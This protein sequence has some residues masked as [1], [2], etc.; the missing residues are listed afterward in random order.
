M[1]YALTTIWHERSR[2]LP[3]ILAVSFSATLITVQGGL[4]I[5]LLSM[6][7]V[8]I[9]Q[10]AA[11]V[12]VG[13]P[14]VRSVD[15]GR[16]IPERWV[17]RVAADPAVERVETC[18]IGFSL[19][20]RLSSDRTPATPEIITIV[21]TRLHPDALGAMDAIRHDPDL[22]AKLA[23]PST[24]AVDES[25]LGRLGDLQLGG[26]AEIF[27]RRVRLVGLVHGYKSLGGPYV[28]CNVDT[29]RQ[30]LKQTSG[31][32]TYLQAK[33][34]KGA[35][36]AATAARLNRAYPTLSAFT[37]DEFSLR[38]RMHWLTTTKAGIA[39]GF[40][41]LLALLV[42]AVV[43]SQTLYGATIAFQREFATMRAMGI[44]RWRLQLTVLTQSLWVGALG[45]LLSVPVVAVLSE[46]AS[47]LGT[48]VRLHPVVLAVAGGVTL[49]MSFVSGLAAMRSFQGVDPAHNIR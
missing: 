6:I 28:F 25:E 36:A 42:G 11:N 2:F 8:P 5:G 14:G 48:Q 33:L 44:P 37:S 35:D 19:W 26:H 15:L 10:S 3:A 23:E 20:S 18:V 7:S 49:G 27:G 45:I 39:V 31:G 29:A 30:L 22:M 43:T 32:V 24:V 17:G 12:W 13:Y 41:A 1:N 4:A 40:T 16:P 47:E 21:G 34:H 46:A 9:D 38:S